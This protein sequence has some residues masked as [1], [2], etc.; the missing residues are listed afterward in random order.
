MTNKCQPLIIAKEY[1]HSF[2]LLSKKK[3]D[4]RTCLPLNCSSCL[5]GGIEAGTLASGPVRGLA[6]RCNR[7]MNFTDLMRYGTPRC[8]RINI[9]PVP[10]K[11]GDRLLKCFFRQ[12]CC[13]SVTL[14]FSSVRLL[15]IDFS[16]C[17]S[18]QWKYYLIAP[19]WK[20]M[21][22]RLCPIAPCMVDKSYWKQR[23]LKSTPPFC[24]WTWTAVITKFLYYS[25][26]QTFRNHSHTKQFAVT[27]VEK[28]PAPW[29]HSAQVHV[30]VGS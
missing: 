18:R 3:F 14:V 9:H 27:M 10:S 16:C 24:C 6:V 30:P 29:D 13:I 20:A 4:N 28:C 19:C 7:L 26:D 1:F 11:T 23:S 22:S 12:D 15:G 2:Y 5:S 17:F 8:L 25:W 21:F